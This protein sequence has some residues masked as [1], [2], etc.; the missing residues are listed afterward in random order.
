MPAIAADEPTGEPVKWDPA[1][2]TKYAVD[3]N[4]AVHRAEREMEKAPVDN[5]P[6]QRTT[7]YEMTQKLRQ[8]EDSTQNLQAKL[9]GGAGADETRGV[10]DRI[11][12]LRRDC[13]EQGRRAMIPEPVLDAL[14]D[15][16]AIHNL[17]MPYYHGKR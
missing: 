14:V 11:E 8:I 5:V 9:Q 12:T 1:R 7:W 4:A 3:L 17:M 16:G 15:A 13:E 10:F 2:V 6:S